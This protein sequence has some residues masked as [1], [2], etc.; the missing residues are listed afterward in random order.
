[1]T[2]ER[3]YGGSFAWK[4]L[5]SRFFDH[6]IDPFLD[7]L[8]FDGYDE[9]WAVLAGIQAN[10]WSDTDSLAVLPDIAEAAVRPTHFHEEAHYWQMLSSPLLQS[11]FLTALQKIRLVVKANEGRWEF[12]CGEPGCDE[13]LELTAH[14]LDWAQTLMKSEFSDVEVRWEREIVDSPPTGVA[15]FT[16][17]GGLYNHQY[18]GYVAA[19][20]YGGR[21]RRLVS[22][23]LTS[24]TES[25]AYVAEMKFLEQAPKS[26]LEDAPT[27]ENA[28]VGLWELWRRY[29]GG[30]ARDVIALTNSF[31]AT[32]DL[33]L[34]GNAPGPLLSLAK[35]T[36][37]PAERFGRLLA[38]S[39]DAGLMAPD[40][41][42]SS[43]QDRLAAL[44][45][46]D[47]VDDVLEGGRRKILRIL[48]FSLKPYLSIDDRQWKSWIDELFHP[49]TN[50]VCADAILEAVSEPFRVEQS[51][52]IGSYILAAMFNALEHRAANR[53]AFADPAAHVDELEEK[54]PLPLILMGG[55][56]YI[57]RPHDRSYRKLPVWTGM[58]RLDIISLTAMMPL[59]YGRDKCGFIEF[60]ADCVYVAKGLGCPRAGPERISQKEMQ[61]RADANLANWCHKTHADL[62]TC[63]S[64]GEEREY[65]LKRAQSHLEAP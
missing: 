33:A 37:F 47:T 35:M 54:F 38:V 63:L 26:L 31:L 60:N 8:D 30:R 56:Y 59:V 15:A 58:L 36:D 21:E 53:D 61:R 4:S 65:W 27:I 2:D 45:K 12:I 44:A 39:N 18:A 64:R 29:H 46:L 48:L 5:I 55:N 9:H 13:H 43:Y 42:L 51:L 28:Y 3:K 6:D 22:V 25:A 11:V 19:L 16:A 10:F 49:V 40:E 62:V 52:P 1:M 32:V 34:L 57:T 23:D 20:G 41:S 7:K 14:A 24:L 50:A 17:T